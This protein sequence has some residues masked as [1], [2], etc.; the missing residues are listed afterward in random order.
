MNPSFEN[1][2]LI[3][4]SLHLIKTSRSTI[5]FADTNEQVKCKH[6]LSNISCFISKQTTTHQLSNYLIILIGA[7]VFNFLYRKSIQGNS[8]FAL[9]YKW[10]RE[11]SVK[12]QSTKSQLTIFV[13]PRSQKQGLFYHFQC[14]NHCTKQLPAANSVSGTF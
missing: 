2:N 1:R 12:V 8:A 11:R 7:C 14:I 3:V 4:S 5:N 13:Q 9:E 10:N 6:I